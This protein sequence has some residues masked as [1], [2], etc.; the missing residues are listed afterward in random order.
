MFTAEN[1]EQNWGHKVCKTKLK[2]TEK[3]KLKNKMGN[4]G[5]R[6][7]KDFKPEK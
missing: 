2:Q 3:F 1:M 5:G 6:K 4:V 7:K